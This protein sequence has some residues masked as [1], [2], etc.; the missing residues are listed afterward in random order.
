MSRLQNVPVIDIGPFLNGSDKM[1]V[2]REV[3]RACRDL[4]FLVIGG[5]G[6]ST[7]LIERTRE[8]GRAFFDLSLE[9]KMRVARPAPG[10]TRGYV[11]ME[12]ESVARSRDP[13]AVAGDLNES[14]MIGPVD[15]PPDDYAFAPAAGQHFAPNLWPAR[16]AGL[17]PAWTEY[18]R[19]MGTLAASLMRIF[20]LGLGLEESYF[21]TMVDRHISRLRVRNYPAPSTPPRPGQIR[22]GAHSDYG[23][24]TIL[25]TEDRPGGLQVFNSADEWV[26]VPILPD[27]FVVNI[28][29]LMARWTNDA[30]VSTL[31]RV[32]NPPA[33]GEAE[34]RRQSLVFFHNPNY[35]APITS[36]PSCVPD[37]GQG[38]YPPTTSG[39]HLRRLFTATQNA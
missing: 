39:E 21:D 33:G 31:H 20:A 27:S 30:W 5:H 17:R 10:V 4:G 9:E 18:Y 13:N 8:A 16:P 34:S 19:A 36:I 29:D 25:C 38:K 14:L 23:S 28:G 12:G 1:R 15:L 6:V 11:G 22:A 2:A 32:V 35:D 26:D 37:G 24:L 3:D 7:G